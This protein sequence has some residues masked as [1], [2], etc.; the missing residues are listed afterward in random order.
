VLALSLALTAAAT[1]TGLRTAEARDALRFQNAVQRTQVLI[2]NRMQG[3][4][5][6]LR[7]TSGLFAVDESVSA[8]EFRAFLHNLELRRRYPGIQGIGFSRRTAP[9]EGAGGRPERHSIVYLE[10]LD[11]RN[12]AALGF[13]MSTEPTRRAA[14]ERARDTGLPAASG[15]VTLVQEIGPHRQAGFLVYFPVYRHGVPLTTVADRRS[16]LLG[17]V[18]SPFRADDLLRGILHAETSPTIAFQVFAGTVPSPANLLHRSSLIPAGGDRPR[19]DRPRFTAYGGFDVAGSPWTIEYSTLPA[20]EAAST[21]RSA[22]LLPLAGLLVSAL[23]FFLTRSLVRAEIEAETANRA[24][25]RFMAT[26]SHEL[27]TPL[28]PVLMVVSTLEAR[29]RANRL[30][31]EMLGDLAMI[32]R[33]VELET[34]LIDDLLDLTRIR[35]GKLEIKHG[36]ADLREILKHAVETS[37]AHVPEIERPRYVLDLAPMD[38]R[39]WA[40]APR[41]TQVF[42]N[43]LNNALKFTPPGG[44]IRVR[45]WK[46]E[47]GRFAIEVADTGAGI[48]PDVLP[49]IFEAFAQGGRFLKDRRGA[50][51]QLGGLGLGLAISRTIVEAHG[52]TLVAESEG[53][54]KGST[55]TVRLP[56]ALPPGTEAPQPEA[57]APVPAPKAKPESPESIHVLLVEDHI[58]AAEALAD[59]LDAT[60][61]RVTVAHCVQE[62]L[63]AAEK[64]DGFDLVLSDIGLPDGTGYDLMRELS[65]RFGLQGIA[66]TGYGMDEDVEKS[67][68]AGFSKHLTK[69]V[70]IET[71]E[72]ALRQ[73]TGA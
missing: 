41:L 51:R 36:E 19:G 45:T 34:R 33:N 5:S 27:R 3:Y 63:E 23:L 16:A 59:Y 10:P 24:K 73:V 71:L 21:R 8:G 22:L 2:E 28:T 56:I 31:R 26:L 44:E 20:F 55:F 38:H 58:D 25:D 49:R 46:E 39:L 65:R 68:A 54:G 50:L 13:D 47:P 70:N 62:A 7:A 17:F 69:P 40:D 6:L 67:R 12:R 66:L 53:P 18:Y 11:R 43:L 61:R 37:A 9:Q 48:E 72:T 42:W 64:G 1:Y 60:G 29:A 15:R 30:S 14:M 52:G 32:R 57:V 35:Q 4:V